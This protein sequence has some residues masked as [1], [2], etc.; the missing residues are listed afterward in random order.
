MEVASKKNIISEDADMIQKLLKSSK[1][2]GIL[3][4][5]GCKKEKS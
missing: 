2:G 4:G 5:G 1:L 3:I